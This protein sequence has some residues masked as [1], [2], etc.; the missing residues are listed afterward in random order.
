MTDFCPEL[1]LPWTLVR[2]EIPRADA[3]TVHARA[4]YSEGGP[5]IIGRHVL[6]ISSYPRI[7]SAMVDAKFEFEDV[8][9]SEFRK[10]SAA[11]LFEAEVTAM[12][13]FYRFLRSSLI[14]L[15]T[16]GFVGNC[17]NFMHYR[18]VL[19]E[20]LLDVVCRKRPLVTKIPFREP[21]SP[22]VA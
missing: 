5:N 8:Y 1:Q 17:P 18:L 9:W 14:E 10:R 3:L 16:R 20:S 7:E 12:Q 22:G 11:A 4:L 6:D 13:T 21:D 19:G 15:Q 2:I